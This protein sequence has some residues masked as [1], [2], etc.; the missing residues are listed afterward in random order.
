MQNT[1]ENCLLEVL[2]LFL[3]HIVWH[4]QL[5]IDNDDIYNVYK[6]LCYFGNVCDTSTRGLLISHRIMKGIC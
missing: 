6:S 4:Y 1:Y 3:F 2:N 5:C